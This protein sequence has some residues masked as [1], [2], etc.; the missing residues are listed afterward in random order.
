L[1]GVNEDESSSSKILTK[2]EKDKQDIIEKGRRPTKQQGS[3]QK[4]AE[5]LGP[6]GS[7]EKRLSSGGVYRGPTIAE[8]EKNVMKVKTSGKGQTKTEDEDTGKAMVTWK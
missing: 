4:S 5:N 8:I 2:Q 6:T 7:G 3:G 1:G